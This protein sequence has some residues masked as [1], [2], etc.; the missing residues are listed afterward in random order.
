MILLDGAFAAYMRGGGA[1]PRRH[2]TLLRC[3][4]VYAYIYAVTLPPLR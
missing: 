3:R 2:D 1:T 4:D